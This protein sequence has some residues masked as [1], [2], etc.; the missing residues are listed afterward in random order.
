MVLLTDLALHHLGC[1]LHGDAADL[2][3]D[4]VHGLLTLLRNVSFGLLLQRSGLCAGF[5]HDL[6]RAGG[7]GLLRRS[8]D[9]VGF[10]AGVLQVLLVLR[11]HGFGFGAQL[12]CICDLAVGLGLAVGDHLFDR[13]Q[14][15]LFEDDQLDDQVAD[16]G[17]KGPAIQRDQRLIQFHKRLLS[18][19]FR[20]GRLMPDTS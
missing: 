5:A 6:F 16:L 15:E 1:D 7:G 8:Y 3:L 14:Q 12:L 9:L 20:I 4:L 10:G 18:L 13:L 2:V 19:L 11:L 17:Q